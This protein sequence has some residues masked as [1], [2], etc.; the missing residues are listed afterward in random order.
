MAHDVFISYSTHDKTTA[1]AVCV[2]L[3][4]NGIQ[5]WIA[6]RDIIPGVDWGEAII[7]AIQTSRMMILVFSSNANDSQQVR[8]E[9]ERAANRGLVIMPLRI[10]NVTPIK[11]LAYFIG[12]LHWLDALTP[13]LERHLQNLNKAVGLQ[14]SRI[15]K[16]KGTIESKNSPSE[17]AEEQG[18]QV[19]IREQRRTQTQARPAR[20]RFKKSSIGLMVVCSL[21]LGLT[22]YGLWHRVDPGKIWIEAN[23][24]LGKAEEAK[25]RSEE[26]ACYDEVAVNSLVVS[27][28]KTK[29][30]YDRDPIS[31]NDF[32]RRR[33][34]LFDDLHHLMAPGPNTEACISQELV[35]VR[36]LYQ[37]NFIDIN[38][39]NSSSE[40]LWKALHNLLLAKVQNEEDRQ[41]ALAIIKQLYDQNAININQLNATRTAL[42]DK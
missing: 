21:G 3:E 6:P 1:D 28:Q 19:R 15:G 8:R 41:Q 27:L 14:L 23:K 13:P 20:G 36:S 35:L 12:P 38:Q 17:I 11:S 22:F 18:R 34:K 26:A 25:Q 30:Q 9:V 32:T 33:K 42:S 29:E 16:D 10:E 5:C 24:V 2:T 7:D 40:I 4:A 39:W 37:K 31:I